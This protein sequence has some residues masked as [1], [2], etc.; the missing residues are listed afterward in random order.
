MSLKFTARNLLDPVFRRTYGAKDDAA[1][2]Y[3]AF[4]RGMTFGIS[5]TYEY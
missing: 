3:S 5:L 4:T 1:T 2:A